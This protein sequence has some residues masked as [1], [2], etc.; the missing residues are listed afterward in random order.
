VVA[1]QIEPALDTVRRS[2]RDQIGVVI[3]APV[4]F[5]RR[6]GDRRI[7]PGEPFVFGV[8]VSNA[9]GPLA[10][11]L[12]NA[13]Y[14]LKVEGS[15]G[16]LIVPRAASLAWHLT[17][18]AGPTPADPPLAPGARVD[19][20]YL[21]FADEQSRLAVGQ[22]RTIRGLTGEVGPIRAGARVQLLVRV[23]ADLDVDFLDPSEIDSPTAIQGLMLADW[24]ARTDSVPPSTNSARAGC[25]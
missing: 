16:A 6:P 1:I 18:R 20:M 5:V 25:R 24:D 8:S 15:S 14:H 13:R 9:G 21:F 7:R 22:V 12:R 11:P 17:P 19:E 23:L 4:P 10:I 3:L 2:F